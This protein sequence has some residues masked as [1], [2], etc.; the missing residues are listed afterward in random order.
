M[1][2]DCVGVCCVRV[3]TNWC[4]IFYFYFAK[5]RS[6]VLSDERS[7]PREII[8]DDRFSVPDSYFLL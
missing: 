4:S 6:H 8:V 1:C 5:S 7:S 3:V 2:D